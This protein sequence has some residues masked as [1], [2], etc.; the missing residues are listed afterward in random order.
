MKFKNLQI[1]LSSNFFITISDEALLIKKIERFISLIKREKA[2]VVYYVYLGT[3]VHFYSD[4]YFLKSFSFA[5]EVYL[6]GVFTG[7]IIQL[8]TGKKY[9]TLCTQFFLPKILSYCDNGEKNVFL[10]GSDDKTIRKAIKKLKD[11][12]KNISVDGHGGYFKDD[13]TIINKINSHDTDLLVV[14]MGLSTQ[15][16]W[17]YANA[18]KLKTHPVIICVGNYVDFMGGKV[19]LPPNFFRKYNLRWLYRIFVE[20]RVIKRYL[21]GVVVVALLIICYIFEKKRL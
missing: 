11:D 2:F 14:G 15:E 8:I 10:L 1:I 5:T 17:V 6:D 3:L 19:D 7:W 9:S 13:E 12:Y 16:K 18:E 21:G 4:E 20:P